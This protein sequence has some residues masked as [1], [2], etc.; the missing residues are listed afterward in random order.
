MSRLRTRRQTSGKWARSRPGDSPPSSTRPG[1]SARNSGRAGV[2]FAGLASTSAT[3][4]VESSVPLPR[5]PARAYARVFPSRTCRGAT[6]TRRPRPA[7]KRTVASQILRTSPACARAAFTGVLIYVIALNPA[8]YT[9][10]GWTLHASMW[11]TCLLSKGEP[12]G[13]SA[14]RL[15][16]PA[17]PSVSQEIRC[18][19]SRGGFLRPPSSPCGSSGGA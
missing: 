19:T 12:S 11:S 2:M 16:G 5:T 10:A 7:R 3:A 15:A 8:P 1:G 18:C 13:E 9:R 4:R 14:S 17:L 6:T